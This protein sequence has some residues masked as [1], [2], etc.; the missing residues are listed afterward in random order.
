MYERYKQFLRLKESGLRREANELTT[1]I[2]SDFWESPSKSFVLGICHISEHSKINHL[3]WRGIV[4]RWASTRLTTDADAIRCLIKTVQ[5]LYNDKEAHGQVGH[6]TEE[7]L[8]RGLLEIEPGDSWAKE[9]LQSF[10]SKWLAYTIHEWPQGVLYGSDGATIKQ[11]DEIL[12]AVQELKSLD[13][14]NTH[15]QLAA[16]VERKTLEY[17]TRITQ[18]G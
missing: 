2:I 17:R 9:K 12:A 15:R 6:I 5:N 18:N 4:F 11:C 7:G 13:T 10:L 14:N 16:D 1:E 8:I 3:L